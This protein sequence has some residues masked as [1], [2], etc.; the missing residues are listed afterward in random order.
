MTFHVCWTFLER[1]W[2][3]LTYESETYEMQN[4]LMNV[5]SQ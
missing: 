3:D 1:E 5:F 2:L 4:F